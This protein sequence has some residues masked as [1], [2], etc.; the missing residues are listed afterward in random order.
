MTWQHETTGIQGDVTLF[1]INIF[2]RE[3]HETGEHISVRDPLYQQNY[4][5]PVYVV[6]VNDEP[7]QF[8]AGEFS[9]NVWGFY[10]LKY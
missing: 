6:N 9:N 7:H 4:K 3:W 5:F 1:G 8:A 2:E 10:T